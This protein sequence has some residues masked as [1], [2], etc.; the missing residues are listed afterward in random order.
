MRISLWRITIKAQQLDLKGCEW[1]CVCFSV[2]AV[3]AMA[4]YQTGN[5]KLLPLL[6]GLYPSTFILRVSS[7]GI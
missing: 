6:P 7:L 3:C 4:V 5:N 2:S 1:E